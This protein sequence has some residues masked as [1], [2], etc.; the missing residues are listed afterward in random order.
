[1][2]DFVTE[3]TDE[4]ARLAKAM[5]AEAVADM[6][7]AGINFGQI[8]AALAWEFCNQLDAKLPPNEAWS[9][10]LQSLGAFSKRPERLSIVDPRSRFEL[11]S[12]ATG[13]KLGEVNLEAVT[14]RSGEVVEVT[15]PPIA[16]E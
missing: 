11:M 2:T 5:I 1:M 6:A 10:K 12:D 8:A 4:K 13:K 15:F 14:L 7:L 9:I 3:T 16:I